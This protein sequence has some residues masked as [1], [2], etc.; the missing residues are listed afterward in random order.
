ME[1]LLRKKKA[2]VNNL[3]KRTR[4]F[5]EFLDSKETYS[6]GLLLDQF[7]KEMEKNNRDYRVVCAAYETGS[8]IHSDIILRMFSEFCFRNIDY[9]TLSDYRTM[10]LLN[11]LQNDVDIVSALVFKKI[12]FSVIEKYLW[13]NA[14]A[15]PRIESDELFRYRVSIDVWYLEMEIKDWVLNKIIPISES[16]NFRRYKMTELKKLMIYRGEIVGNYRNTTKGQIEIGKEESLTL[17]I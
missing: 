17:E 4:E 12:P 14:S 13:L 8:F 1:K 15:L 16:E 7:Q 6:S 3:K 5:L 11:Y 9:K 2:I 10:Q